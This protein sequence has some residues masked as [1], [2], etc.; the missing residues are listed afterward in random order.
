VILLIAKAITFLTGLSI[1]A[2]STNTEVQGGG[3]YYTR[4]G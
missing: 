3:P 1:A 2:I 4:E